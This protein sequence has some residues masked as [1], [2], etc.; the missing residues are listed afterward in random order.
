MCSTFSGLFTDI[1]DGLT[2]RGICYL[3]WVLSQEIYIARAASL[4]MMGCSIL[5]I[6]VISLT[7][8]HFWNSSCLDF[9]LMRSLLSLSTCE[10]WHQPQYII[11]FL[12]V[13][14]STISSL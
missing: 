8:N 6:S 3:W 2:S 1:Y 13:K 5:K 4:F 7:N 12:G 14:S 11:A 10:Q 9:G